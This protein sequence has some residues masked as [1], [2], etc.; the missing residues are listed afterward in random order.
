MLTVNHASSAEIVV[1]PSGTSNDAG[2]IQSALNGIREG[3]TLRL[4]G[5]FF[6]ASTL[7]LP[8]NFTWILDGSLALHEDADLDRVG[9]VEPGI[10]A[11]R[12]TGITEQAGGAT[13]IVMSGGT[14]YGYD[15]HSG[16]SSV[17]FLNFVSVTRSVFQDFTINEGSDDGFTLG[18]GSR[19][20]ECRNLIGSGAHGNALT[21][22][23]EYNK[24]YD[25][26]AEDCDSDGWTPKCRYSEFHRCIGRRNAGPGFGMYGRVDGSGDP[27]DLGETIAG[28]KFYACESYDNGRGGFD[29]DISST[30]GEGGLV[31][32]NYIQAICYNNK[33]QGVFFRNKRPN[34]LIENNVVDIVAYGN[35]GQRNDGSSSS[36]GGGVSAE[37]SDE[38]PV[39]GIKGW[40]I[41]YDNLGWDVNTNKATH[42]DIV[43]YNPDDQ[44]PAVLKKGDASNILTEISFSCVDPLDAWCQ[45]KYCGTPPP[46]RPGAP[47]MLSAHVVSFDQ[48][49]LSWADTSTNEDGFVIEQKTGEHFIVIGMV[50]EN[51]TTFSCT[52]LSEQTAYTYRIQAFNITGYSPYSNEVSA[53]TETDTSFNAQHN[54]SL[55]TIMFKIFPNPLHELTRI[56]YAIR[57]EEFVSIRVFDSSGKELNTL[58]H[59]RK[60][61]GEY[62]AVFHGS[63]LSGGLYF[64]NIQCGAYT[65]TKKIIML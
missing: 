25:C 54:H 14:Y 3:D 65:E 1:I 39:R 12:P 31:R 21:D 6:I 9:W 36:F 64:I 10:D 46:S 23:G 18:P 58:V 7:Y 22:K 2:I 63:E 52:G 28:N 16:S 59:E 29:F 11:R 15:V 55:D 30:C 5:D 34:S 35:L 41:C 45:H 4:N 49:D 38:S 20:N 26:I 47:S 33:M 19:Y 24:W 44:A 50:H 57:K 62:T 32:D 61:P 40:V 51:D 48:I 27:V 43:V 53:I 17:R 37:G 60:P 56:K 42:C 8:S 13:N